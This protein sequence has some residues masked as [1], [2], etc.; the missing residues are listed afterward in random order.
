VAVGTW[1]Q[2]WAGVGG[3]GWG[4]VGEGGLDGTGGHVWGAVGRLVP[5]RVQRAA[6]REQ[7]PFEQRGWSA[8]RWTSW[9]RRSCLTAK[10]P[11]VV[12]QECACHARIRDDEHA[13]LHYYV[14]VHPHRS[15]VPTARSH[16]LPPALWRPRIKS[17]PPLPP[18]PPPPPPHSHLAATIPDSVKAALL[19]RIKAFMQEV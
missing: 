1:G 7:T 19:L 13:Q 18:P 4:W 9:W 8:S 12:P 6:W 5:S 17:N 11:P 14:H 10:V 2:G 15:W 16:P 3:G